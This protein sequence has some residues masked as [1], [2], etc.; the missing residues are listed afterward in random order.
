[1]EFFRLLPRSVQRQVWE[2]DHALFRRHVGPTL[3]A[4]AEETATVLRELE[5]VRLRRSHLP[6]S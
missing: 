4:Y 5:L 2:L 6:S 1:M 3:R